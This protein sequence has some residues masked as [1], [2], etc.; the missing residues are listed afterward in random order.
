[1]R[2][3]TAEQVAGI[4]AAGAVT[5]EILDWLGDRVVA[6][7]TTEQIDNWVREH[8]EGRGAVPATL[9][10][11]GYPKSCCTSINEVVCHGIPENRPLVDGDIINIDV[12]SVLNGFYGDAS[13]MYLVGKVAPEAVRLSEVTR[14]CLQR[15]VEAVRPGGH[16]GD[17]GAAIQAHAEASG[18]SVVRAFVGHGTGVHFHEDP[19]VPH[20]G[21]RGHGERIVEGSVFTIEPMIN[22][23]HWD[24][25]M[26]DDG[27][28]VLTA[29]GS[30]SAQWEHTLLVGPDGAEILAY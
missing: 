13:R 7:V 14:Q 12:T 24:V 6:G 28:T 8:L 18:F 4:K 25:R 19:Q 23:G 5:T 10:Y 1:M 29:D 9:G 11:R 20:F 30:L 2:I 27:W 16:I 3:K 17:I 15:G 22:A 21:R 26:L